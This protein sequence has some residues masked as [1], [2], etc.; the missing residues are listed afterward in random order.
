MVGM[1]E[2]L[3]YRSVAAPGLG[4]G[5]VER[6]VEQSGENNRERFIT[7]FLIYDGGRFLQVLEGSPGNVDLLMRVIEKDPRHGQV[8]VLER[9]VVTERW[10]P[11]WD[12]KHLLTFQGV[13]ALEAV[14]AQ[15]K[16][17]DGGRELVAL[18]EEFVGAN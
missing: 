11:S 3:V 9:A 1:L 4:L 12:M 18:T 17:K 5:E 8:E 10:F 6:I 14:R 2:R 15:V 16:G 13:P 7:G